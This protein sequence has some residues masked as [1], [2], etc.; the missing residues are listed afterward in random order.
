M[1]KPKVTIASLR[2][3]LMNLKADYQAYREKA[4]AYIFAT[5]S[6]SNRRQLMQIKTITEK[7]TVNA[8]SIAELV[9]LVNLNNGTGE[10][11][12]LETTNGAQELVVIAK[13]KG[14]SIPA[15]LL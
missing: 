15:G 4:R 12:V 8:M 6:F 3:E 5:N 2:V 7:G 11:T 10:N 9:M 1:K 13:R 14:P